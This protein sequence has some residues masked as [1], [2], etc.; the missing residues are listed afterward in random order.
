MAIEAIIFDMDGLLVDSE[1]TWDMARNTIVARVGKLWNKQ[2]HF[3]VM[4]VLAQ[5]NG[6]NI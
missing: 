1:P 2:D 4:G 5:Q 3:N 6:H